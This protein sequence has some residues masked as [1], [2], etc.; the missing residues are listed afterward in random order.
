MLEKPPAEHLILYD[1]ICGLC[2]RFIRFVLP[3]DRRARFRYAAIQSSSGRRLLKDYGK[4]PDELVTFYVIANYDSGETK[5]LSKANAALFVLSQLNTPWR[6]AWIF[7]VLPGRLLDW[8]Y[9]RIAQNRYRLFGRYETCPIPP[10]QWRE[11][12]LED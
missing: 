12:F 7:R 8:L 1:G 11:R 5:L 10:A 9:D 6:F 4:D 3:R 2:N